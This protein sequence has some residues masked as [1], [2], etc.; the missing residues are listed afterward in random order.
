MPGEHDARENQD[1]PCTIVSLREE[2]TQCAIGKKTLAQVVV[3]NLFYL[4][5]FNLLLAKQ[6]WKFES[7]ARSPQSRRGIGLTTGI[8]L[9]TPLSYYSLV[10]LQKYSKKKRLQI[11]DPL[12]MCEEC[13]N[14]KPW[15]SRSREFCHEKYKW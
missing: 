12:V 2:K 3:L 13:A 8:G 14:L 9:A 1:N 7:H 15:P 11:I 10:Y 5:A 4:A 6:G